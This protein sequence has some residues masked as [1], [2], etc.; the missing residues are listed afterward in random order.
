MDT[1]PV[2]LI[3]EMEMMVTEEDTAE[4]WGSGLVPVLGTPRLVAILENAAVKALNGHLPPG[5]TSVG[6]RMD[7]RHLAPTPVGMDVR[8][9]AELVEVS[10]RRLVFQVEAWD[11][12]EKIGDGT[13]E[14]FAVD[15]E[16]FIAAAEAKG[17]SRP[18]AEAQT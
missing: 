8:A 10:G 18:N 16:R 7:I 1:I 11:E 2:G 12:V 5:Q 17:G 9:Q 3:G 6:G 14:R 13:H 15:E 4:R